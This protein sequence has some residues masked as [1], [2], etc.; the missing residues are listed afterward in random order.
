MAIVAVAIVL[1]FHLKRKPTELELRMAKPMG[2]IFW[3]MSVACLV[4]GFANYMRK[5]CPVP[6]FASTLSNGK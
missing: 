1:S 3:A 5:L 6:L 4:V 2:A